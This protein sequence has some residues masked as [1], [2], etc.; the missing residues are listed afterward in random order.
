MRPQFFIS[1]GVLVFLSALAVRAANTV[2]WPSYLGDKERSHYSPLKQINTRNV[3]G[4]EVAWTYQSGGAR[5]DGRSQIQC[6][7]LIVDGVLYGTSPACRMCEAAAYW[8]N[9]ARLH[10]GKRPPRL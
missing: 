2:D 6:N 3:K 4:L 10:P 7:P 9:I 8:A 1:T 5:P